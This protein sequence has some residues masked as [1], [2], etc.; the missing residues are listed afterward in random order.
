MGVFIFKKKRT[1]IDLMRGGSC[2]NGGK[3]VAA[4]RGAREGHRCSVVAADLM[5]AFLSPKQIKNTKMNIYIK[6]K[7][8][9]NTRDSKY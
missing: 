5:D 9:L 7:D 2:D 8:T 1:G 3:E 6:H 4:A